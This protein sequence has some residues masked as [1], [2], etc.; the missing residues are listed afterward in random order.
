LLLLSSTTLLLQAESLA[1]ALHGPHDPGRFIKKLRVEGGFGAHMGHILK[2][3]PNVTDLFI[4][5]A[6][7]SPDTTS[8]LVL[9]LSSLN[10]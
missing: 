9:A 1:V 6:I 7:H 4:S 3:A 5:T 2:S 8:G 10:P